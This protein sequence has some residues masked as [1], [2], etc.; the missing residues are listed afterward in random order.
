MP[1]RRFWAGIA[2]SLI[3]ILAGGTR[4]AIAQTV[5]D[6]LRAMR[7]E[8]AQL[9]HEL[10]EVKEELRQLKTPVL[11][12]ASRELNSVPSPAESQTSAAVLQESQ[13]QPSTEDV[14]SLLQARIEEQS[15]T[16]VESNSKFPM[17]LFGTI[18]SNTFLNTGEP[19]WLDIGNVVMPRPAGLPTGSFTSSL[20]QTRFGGIIDGPQIGSAKTSGLWAMDFFGGMPNFQTGEV[21]GLPRLLYAYFR[22][23]GKKTALHAGLDHVILAPKNP[24]SMSGMAFPILFRAGNLYLRAPQIRL[25]QQLASGSF[26][27]IRLTGGILAPVGG[28]A[29][30]TSFLFVPPNL[31]GERSRRPAVQAR[32]SWSAE[33]G[34]LY[35]E[36]TWEFGVSGHYSREVYTTG[37]SPSRAGAV[38][39]DVTFRRFGIGGELFVGRNI[40]PY[41]A[42]LA[43]IAKSRGGFVEARFAATRKLDF[44]TGIGT[45]QLYDF[46]RFNPTLARNDSIFANTIYQFTPEFGASLEYR[47]LETK[48]RVGALRRNHHFNLTFAYSF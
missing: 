13:A 39:F 9:R 29:S 18:V 47:L 15:Q 26:G 3:M 20:R 41:G 22:V 4:S 36:P 17:K 48:P 7:A 2:L 42:Y 21:I 23:D 1:T 34:G 10:N 45:D 25:E 37:V 6:E 32:M 24:T 14:I 11:Q 38:D 31:G 35:E 8:I 33:A 40:E 44:N 5:E 27:Q 19:N 30:T 16:K 12:F 28:D 43:K 46:V